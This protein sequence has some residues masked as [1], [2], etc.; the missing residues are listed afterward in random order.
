MKRCLLPLAL[1]L[2]CSAM[3]T[4]A[5]AARRNRAPR[6]TL[7]VP[8][9]AP[10]AAGVAAAGA[11]AGV[12]TAAAAGAATQPT[13]GAPASPTDPAAADADLLKGLPAPWKATVLDVPLAPPPPAPNP[14]PA[15][16]HRP[17][18]KAGQPSGAGGRLAGDS[19][20]P[21]SVPASST[22]RVLIPVSPRMGLAAFRSGDSF[23]I[24]VDNAEPMDTSALRGDGVF[25]TLT[26]TTL[27]GATL[28]QVKLP[29][30]R[31]F[32]LS[33]QAE[34]WILGDKP[35]PGNVYGDRRVINPIVADGGILYPMRKPGR[36]LTIADP[37][38]GKKLF[39]GTST[40]DD[41]GIL[42]FRHGDGY[43]VWPTTEGVVVAASSPDVGLRAT[44]EGALLTSAVSPLADSK[45]AV[46][47]NTVDLDWLGLQNLP[48]DQLEQRLHKALLAAADSDPAQ[49]F[50]ARLEEARAAFGVG[51]FLEARGILTVA[52]EDDPEE[53]VRP[54]VSFLLA[55]SELLSGNMDGAFLL[56]GPWP[57]NEQRATQLWRGLYLASRGGHEAEA[58][59]LL[60]RDFSRLDNYP[61]SVRS[62]LLPFAAEQIGRYGS[63]ED[64]S[65]LDKLP[66]GAA[67]TLAS[68]FRDLRTGRRSQAYDAFNA[69]S[70][71]PDPVVAE[72]ALEQKISLD[73][74]DGKL[75]PVAAADM[76]SSLMPDARLAGREATVRLLQADA[77]M[78]AHKWPEALAT[79]D[80]VKDTPEQV[81]EPVLSPMLFQTL[82]A[83]ASEVVK[84]TDRDAILHGAAM[85]RAHLSA[86]QPGTKKGEILM[87]Y[88]KMLLGLGLADEAQQAF[89][90][91]VPMLDS[92]ELKALAGQG[93]A[94]SYI[95]LKDL[96]GATDVLK[97]TDDPSLPDDMKSSRRRLQARINLARGDQTAAL[98]LLNGDSF[99][100]SLDM[101]ARIHESR[102]EW[103]AAVASVRK[104]AEADIPPHGPLSAPQQTLALR[105][106]SDASQASDA[107]TLAWLAQLVGDRTM[108]GESGRVFRL[109]TQVGAPKPATPAKPGA[110]PAA[111]TP[112]RP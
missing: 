30:T 48:D 97:R 44:P 93:L 109:L 20:G 40:T 61:N 16:G 111:T 60:A 110:T 84:D 36:V 104:M 112:A 58:A 95:A 17:G 25:S 103:P 50:A 63:A 100:D 74:S 106:A 79:L 102:G 33:Q 65:V 15:K 23:V 21:V 66:K 47:A 32:F 13:P 24:V 53:A 75:T 42:A 2:S 45:V 81:S 49:R 96:D 99:A 18:Q 108:D 91:A 92:P 28:L 86:L 70:V 83:V 68:A 5:D 98:G 10:V 34:G 73:M 90:D 76:F 85:L 6:T 105:L 3:T 89:S 88:G 12:A 43:D 29:D 67:Y 26:V 11:A 87:A 9:K 77:Y 64:L 107:Q 72:K 41:G 37:A 22:S 51:A 8:P 55:A 94:E 35:P 4:V 80:L 27:P 1:L 54:E 19:S 56:E 59:H 71:D 101:T 39:V 31:Q 82:A 78:R 62:V 38:S 69:L 52:L 7:S 57:D 46:Y 14:T